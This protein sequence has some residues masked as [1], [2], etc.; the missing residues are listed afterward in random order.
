MFYLIKFHNFFKKV[1][2]LIWSNFYVG[3]LSDNLLLERQIKN[4]KSIVNLV[5]IAY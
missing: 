5:S 3:I 4:S 2:F 1:Y